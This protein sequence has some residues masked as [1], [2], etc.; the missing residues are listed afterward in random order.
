MNRLLS[1]HTVIG[2]LNE[3][4]SLTLLIAK[5]S[6]GRSSALNIH[7]ADLFPLHALLVSKNPLLCG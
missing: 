5:N 3:S 4:C 1:D 7:G 6:K 2:L